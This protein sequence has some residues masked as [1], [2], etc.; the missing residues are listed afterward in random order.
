[1]N[2]DVQQLKPIFAE[3]YSSAEIDS[4]CTELEELLKQRAGSKKSKQLLNQRDAAFI[5][6]A[7]SIVDLSS[8]KSPL[9]VLD[10]TFMRFKLG[11]PN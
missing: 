8:G 10:E 4:L 7:N 9:A 6:Y 1:M 2:V 3:L 5:C 11:K